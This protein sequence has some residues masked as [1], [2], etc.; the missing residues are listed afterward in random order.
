[1]EFTC[2][3]ADAAERQSSPTAEPSLVKGP[4]LQ[5]AGPKRKRRFGAAIWFGDVLIH[6]QKSPA[7][8][9][10]RAMTAG[11]RLRWE[12]NREYA[13]YAKRN[14]RPVG[15]DPQNSLWPLCLSGEKK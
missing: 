8:G 1:L 12:C 3:H 10:Q 14:S 9:S 11:V 13:K 15:I 2:D 5:G 4:K 6:S 7:K